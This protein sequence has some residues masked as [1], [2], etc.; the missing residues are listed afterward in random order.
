MKKKLCILLL[1][2]CLVS[3]S[4][5]GDNTQDMASNNISSQE[6]N[7]DVHGDRSEKQEVKLKELIPNPEDFF[8]E[9]EFEYVTTDTSYLVYIDYTSEEEWDNYISE[10]EAFGVWTKET[11]KSDYSWYVNSEDELYKLALD[12]YGDKNEYLTIIVSKEKTD[13]E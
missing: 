11:Y 4:A 10:C 13:E 9:T 6:S 3:M 1:G 12:R 7:S 2:L 8:H 5:C